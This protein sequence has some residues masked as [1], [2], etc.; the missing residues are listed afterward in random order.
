[1]FEDGELKVYQGWGYQLQADMPDPSEGF[2]TGCWGLD[3]SKVG[4]IQ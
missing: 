4:L 3:F 1:M 2:C